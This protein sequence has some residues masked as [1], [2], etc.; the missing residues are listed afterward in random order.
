MWVIINLLAAKKHKSCTVVDDDGCILKQFME[1]K[2]KS[3]FF[4]EEE[5]SLNNIFGKCQMPPEP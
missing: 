5:G 4:H 1:T 2:V 3:E